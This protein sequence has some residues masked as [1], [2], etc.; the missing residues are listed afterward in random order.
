MNTASNSSVKRR[1]V[2]GNNAMAKRPRVFI[3]ILKI[4]ESIEIFLWYFN[5]VHSLRCVYVWLF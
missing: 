3:I 2:N 1:V 5:Q 4:P